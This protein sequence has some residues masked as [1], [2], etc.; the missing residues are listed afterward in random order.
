MRRVHDVGIPRCVVTYLCVLTS[1]RGGCLC[2][3]HL[4]RGEID[5][6][7]YAWEFAVCVARHV[8]VEHTESHQYVTRACLL[9]S[10]LSA[11]GASSHAWALVMGV[12]LVGA[13]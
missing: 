6:I 7:D 9:L 3:F 12:R 1:T 10:R 5:E 13:V 4:R 11:P 2:E 8:T